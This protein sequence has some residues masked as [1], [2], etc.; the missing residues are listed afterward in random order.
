MKKLKN[1][2]EQHSIELPIVGIDEFGEYVSL[3]D[4]RMRSWPPL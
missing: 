4:S 1:E 2:S 3:H